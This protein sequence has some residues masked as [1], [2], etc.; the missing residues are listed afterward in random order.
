MKKFSE[1]STANS[2]IDASR[3]HPARIDEPELPVL[4][5]LNS[6]LNPTLRRDDETESALDYRRPVSRSSTSS[7]VKSWL[8]RRRN[9]E[10]A[11][12]TTPPLWST[13]GIE[14]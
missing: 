14:V 1:R 12:A 11:M 7:D 3:P 13:S 2:S 9:K 8:R 6:Q 4:E 10:S 5:V